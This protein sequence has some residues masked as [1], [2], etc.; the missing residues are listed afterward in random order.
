MLLDMARVQRIDNARKKYVSRQT[1]KH[2]D[3]RVLI[4]FLIVCEGE[5]TE[6]N[7]FRGFPEKAGEVAFKME[8]RGEG[9]S[10]RHIVERAIELKKESVYDSVWVVFDK[11]DFTSQEFNAA[12]VRAKEHHIGCAWSNEAFELW[13]LL[14]FHNRTTPMGRE[15]YKKAIE[16]AMNDKI[17]HSRGKKVSFKYEKNSTFMYALLDRY[18][19][20]A[21]AIQWAKELAVK[22]KDEKFA[23]H[24]P[25]THVFELVEELKNGPKSLAE[26]IA[27]DLR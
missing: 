5:K 6:P 2:G 8:V 11:D 24:N 25:C 19:N 18:G 4:R 12:I 26:E 7:Y 15:D 23:E 10:P 13:Y 21:Q 27:K 14:H 16:D 17:K 3:K 1:K 9:E 22:Y 20:Q